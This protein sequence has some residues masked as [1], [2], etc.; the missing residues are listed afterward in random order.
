MKNLRQRNEDFTKQFDRLTLKDMI[1]KKNIVEANRQTKKS[2]TKFNSL[3]DNF[4]ARMLELDPIVPMRYVWHVD[5][6][7]YSN[8]FF[9]SDKNND[10][11]RFSIADQGLIC[12]NNDLN[13]I[14]ANNGLSSIGSFF[15]FVDDSFDGWMFRAGL[16]EDMTPYMFGMDFWRID[17][18]AFNAKWYIDPNIKNDAIRS[19]KG[20][21][22]INYI[23]T[24]TNV[25]SRALTMFTFN[26]DM[27]IRELPKLIM[28]NSPLF[29]VSLLKPFDRVNRWIRK[30]TL[31]A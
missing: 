1:L 8:G 23:C 10:F 31:A 28:T 14:F 18:H 29:P 24:P 11:K 19:T 6:V 21:R 20:E 15:P 4:L 13:A 7:L 22:P 17:T 25:P 2:P 3:E 26:M 27:Y 9:Y 16:R 5:A 30:K 12:K